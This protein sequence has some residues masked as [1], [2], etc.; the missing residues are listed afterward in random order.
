MALRFSGQVTVQSA[1]QLAL[2]IEEGEFSI[3]KRGSTSGRPADWK[4]IWLAKVPPRVQLFAWRMCKN[5]LPTSESLARRG[6][7]VEEGCPLCISAEESLEHTMLRCPFSRQAWALALIP[8]TLVSQFQGTAE[9]WLCLG[10][11]NFNLLLIICC[12]IWG[13]PNKMLF[14]NCSITID[15]LA[16]NADASKK[17][18]RGTDLSMVEPD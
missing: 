5:A 10:K 3:L 11:D 6:V 12:S 1:Y 14:E 13:A 18:L 4:F 8:W 17:F 9:D 16:L 15:T 7:R 2:S